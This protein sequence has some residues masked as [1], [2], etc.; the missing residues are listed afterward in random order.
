MELMDF[1]EGMAHNRSAGKARFR[2]HLNRNL[3][4]ED[5]V[6]ED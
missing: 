1:V 5:S 4:A 6:S 2:R 3:V